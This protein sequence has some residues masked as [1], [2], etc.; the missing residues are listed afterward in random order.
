MRRTSLRLLSS[1]G[2]ALAAAC[3][4]APPRTVPVEP[5]PT[6]APVEATPTHE[7]PPLVWH[8][9]GKEPF[10]LAASA[11]RPVFLLLARALDAG[12]RRR[13]AALLD[14][15]ELLA[16]LAAEFVAVKADPDEQPH[17]VD[18]GL[19]AG[20]RT[21][22][23][24]PLVLVLTPLRIPYAVCEG[25]TDAVEA[26]ARAAG[27]RYRRDAG[28]VRA[29]AQAILAALS[30]SQGATAG[31]TV[32]RD[33]VENARRRA[34]ARVDG[35]PGRTPPYGALRLL[36]AAGDT[37]TV[38]RAVQ[39]LVASPLHQAGGGFFT[40]AAGPDGAVAE[41][42]QTLATQALFL[43]TAA[44][45]QKAAGDRRWQPVAATVADWVLANLRLS[46]GRFRA[47]VVGGV[48][49][50]RVLP[51]WNGLMI[52][53]LA[54]SSEAFTRPKD[55]EAAKAAAKAFPLAALRTVD[56]HAA[57]AW[58][59]LELERVTTDRA[60]TESALRIVDQAV[61][62]LFDTDRGGF[63]TTPADDPAPVR[64]RNAFDGDV[65]SGN[66]LMA[67]VLQRLTEVSGRQS[68][69]VLARR[70]VEAF[71][72]DLKA[73][74]SGMESLAAAALPLV[75]KTVA[76]PA[77]TPFTV[78]ASR[79]Q[80]GPIAVELLVSPER[81]AP[82]QEARAE[83][84]MMLPPGWEV[85]AHGIGSRDGLGMSVALL[86]RDL[87]AG[88]AV[89]PAAGEGRRPGG[90]GT[91]PVYTGAVRV[92]LP[93]RVPAELAPGPR[94]LRLRVRYQA[95]EAGRCQPPESVVLERRLDVSP[96]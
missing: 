62:R 26:C 72:A 67:D 17:L 40:R 60:W 73:A 58:G 2:L 80:R 36:L 10:D 13:S 18:L 93:V 33:E 77:P 1:A 52:G 47:G 85:N 74:P 12:D 45:L 4:P 6:E 37:A 55:L 27:E 54:G 71:A 41:P 57:M 48:A 20:K 82:G 16:K 11:D 61:H 81:V 65:P 31:G 30:L 35:A 39:R 28:E 44:A 43:H 96:S 86:D 9:W 24:P 90:I 15:P 69:A 8:A 78:G 49:D 79:V 19:A 50:D 32:G 38:N 23:V 87:K 53:A 29:E 76:T 70:T 3:T 46:D 75:P 21:S 66:A 64:V 68:Y 88:T 7:P 51:A 56:D 94:A 91:V 22:S 83:V 5:A 14:R 34:V 25:T 63:F 89:Y 42:D 59:L 84:V 92:H 95:C